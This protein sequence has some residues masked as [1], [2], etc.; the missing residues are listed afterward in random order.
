[1]GEIELLPWNVAFVLGDHLVVCETSESVL[2]KRN[3]M[4][5]KQ[6]GDLLRSILTTSMR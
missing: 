1:M 2:H 6:T 3:S 4:P 5:F